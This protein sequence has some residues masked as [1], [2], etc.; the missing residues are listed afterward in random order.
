MPDLKYLSLTIILNLRKYGLGKC[1]TSK[2]L[3]FMVSGPK[4]F[5]FKNYDVFMVVWDP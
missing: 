4:H 1:A 3:V 5:K 2:K